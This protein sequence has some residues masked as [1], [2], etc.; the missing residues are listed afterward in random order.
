MS[1]LALKARRSR[2]RSGQAG[3]PDRSECRSEYR[4]SNASDVDR[5]A[6]RLVLVDLCNP[7]PVGTGAGDIAPIPIT[8]L[9]SSRPIGI[10][11]TRHHDVATDTASGHDHGRARHLGK[12]ELEPTW[13]AGKTAES[14]LVTL[15][16]EKHSCPVASGGGTPAKAAVADRLDGIVGTTEPD[17]LDAS[18]PPPRK[19]QCTVPNDPL[20]RCRSTA[21]STTPEKTQRSFRNEWSRRPAL[22]YLRPT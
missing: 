17:R 11:G 4:P 9:H 6:P 3:D 1:R 12:T 2:R 5:T 16:V 19:R 15:Q 18:H 13:P 8:Q 10:G 20:R 7:D 14:G 21:L 22:Q